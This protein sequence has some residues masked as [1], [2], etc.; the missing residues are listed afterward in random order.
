ML[1]P[2]TPA[3]CLYEP[4]GDDGLLDVLAGCGEPLDRGVSAGPAS[5]QIVLFKQIRS[6]F[7]F[8]MVENPPSQLLLNDRS[9]SCLSRFLGLLTVSRTG[10]R[11]SVSTEY[12]SPYGC[13][14]PSWRGY[15]ERCAGCSSQFSD[16][17][18]VM[19][20]DQGSRH[21]MS[22][23][24]SARA[25]PA[26]TICQQLQYPNITVLRFVTTDAAR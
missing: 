24:L 20:H 7:V 4:R 12:F 14:E 22:M 6:K 21:G 9:P 26:P 15:K 19:A 18:C 17:H 13:C 10:L 11:F 8:L 2:N 1:P 5:Y 16:F 3:I 23:S 25:W